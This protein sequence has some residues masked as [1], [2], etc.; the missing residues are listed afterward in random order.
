MLNTISWNFRVPEISDEIHKKHKKCSLKQARAIA[1]DFDIQK[2]WNRIARQGITIDSLASPDLDDAIHIEKLDGKKGWRLQISIASPTELIEPNSPVEQEAIDR[3]TSVYFGGNH[4]H[5]MLPNIIATDISSLNHHQH[6]LTLT[7]E[8]ILN[9]DF[10]VTQKDLYQSTFYNRQRHSPESFTQAITH[11]S[12]PE[13]EYFSHMHELARGLRHTRE[14]EFRIEHFDDAD[15][16]ITMWEKILGHSNSHI[17]SFVIQEFMLLAN[18]QIAELMD[19]NSVHGIYRFHMPELEFEKILPNILDRAEYSPTAWFHKGLWISKYSHFTSPIRRLADYISHRQLVCLLEGR[20]EFYNTE[21]IEQLCSYINLQ[22][23]ATLSNQKD[24]LLDMHGKRIVRKGKKNPQDYQRSMKQH[25]RHRQE[26]WLRTPRSIREFIM[27]DMIDKK[28]VEDWIIRKFLLSGET[29]IIE[30]MRDIILRDYSTRKYVNI[31]G[32]VPWI[33]YSESQFVSKW[34]LY[35]R[36]HTNILWAKFTD[37][38]KIQTLA[39]HDDNAVLPEWKLKNLEIDDTQYH[40]IKEDFTR[41]K[42]KCLK[43]A[44]AGTFEF[45]LPQK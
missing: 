32:S 10:E 19:E 2:H 41:A 42:V 45:I 31:F 9:E 28:E 38:S 7:L 35:Y 34:V 17:S 26:N 44:I 43:K 18:T 37:T 33:S 25:I 30:V 14:N 15:R 29:E 13:Y 22:I 16:K 4:I 24:E 40:I 39:S 12:D 27:Q 23:T 36:V 8:L 6:R 3:A 20:Q 5:H 1:W 21:Q 11:T